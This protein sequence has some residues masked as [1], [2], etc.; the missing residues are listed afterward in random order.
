MV[1]SVLALLVDL[2]DFSS[3]DCECAKVQCYLFEIILSFQRNEMDGWMD[4]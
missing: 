1:L 3:F 4:R 2:S